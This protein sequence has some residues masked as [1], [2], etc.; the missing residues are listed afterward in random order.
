VRV[1]DE[2]EDGS[3][4]WI[5]P[6][7]LRRCSHALAVDGR[8][9]VIDPVDEDGLDERINAAGEPAGVIQLLDRHNRDCTEL[10]RRLAVPLHYL[11]APAPFVAIPL[12]TPPR[13]NEI[14]LWWP[15]RRV[16]VCAD[17][18]GTAADYFRTPGER[19]GVHPLLRLTPPR[20][21]GRLDPEHVLVGH[22]EGVHEQATAALREALATSRRR[23]PAV[24]A[25]AVRAAVRRRRSR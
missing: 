23:L 13:W 8:V 15:E 4:G 24:L 6:G 17:A 1:C 20:R 16:L 21:L 14:A 22:G 19:L 18:L 5:E 2:L 12:A 11:A 7:F 10:A 9:Y 25:G 3:F